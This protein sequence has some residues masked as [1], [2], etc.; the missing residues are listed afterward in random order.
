MCVWGDE[1]R[2]G[3]NDYDAFIEIPRSIYAFS[4]T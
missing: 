4:E 2:T 3:L 1:N